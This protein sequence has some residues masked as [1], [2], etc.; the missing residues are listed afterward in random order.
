MPTFPFLAEG[1]HQIEDLGLDRHVEGRR[2]LVGDDDVGLRREGERDHHPLAH[3]ARELVRVLLHPQLRLGDPDLPEQVHGAPPRG[4]LAG[5]EVQVNGLDELL[6]DGLEGIQARQR[7]LEDHPDPLAADLALLGVVQA[8][9]AP[10]RVADLARG[11]LSGRL[12]EPDDRI[13]DRRLA[14]PRFPYHPEDFPRLDR[15]RDVVDGDE[16]PPSAR[17][18]HPQVPDVE[19]GHR[20]RR[21]LSFGLRA[22]RSQSPRRFTASTSTTRARPG[23]MVIHHSPEKRKSFPTRMRVPSEGVVGGTPTPRKLSVASVM[24]RDRE[25]DGGDHQ[26][27]THYVGEDVPEED[28][29]APDADDPR[30]LHVLLVLL[31]QGGAPDGAGV[32]HPA[33][34]PD[35]ED[36]DVERELVVVVAGSTERATPSMRSAIRIAGNDSCTSATRMM[37]ASSRPPT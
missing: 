11:H 33:G 23:K 2:R 24:N 36:E 17:E 16:A 3:A 12:Q 13:S 18:L 14:G 19:E 29:A 10:S 6:L 28:G 26:H 4:R 15:E 21:H 34:D 5:P 27:R 7:V 30:G 8:V 22:S 35:G 20:R 32:L 1:P 31:D 9:D 25:V 37:K